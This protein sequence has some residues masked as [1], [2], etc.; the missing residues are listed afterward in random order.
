MLTMMPS[1]R[2]GLTDIFSH[3]R[4]R[5]LKPRFKLL[6]RAQ[7]LPLQKTFKMSERIIAPKDFAIHKHRGHTKCA[8]QNCLLCILSQEIFHFGKRALRDDLGTIETNVVCNASNHFGRL[9]TLT[10]SAPGCAIE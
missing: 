10:E 9:D 4:W 1:S 5:N 2:I 3:R 7:R 6:V 8:S